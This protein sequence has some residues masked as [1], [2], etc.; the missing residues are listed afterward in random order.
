VVRRAGDDAV[1][2]LIARPLF[3]LMR[4]WQRAWPL[5][6]GAS[7]AVVKCSGLQIG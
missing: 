6:L 1:Q 5:P 4:F 2:S 3:L 7:E